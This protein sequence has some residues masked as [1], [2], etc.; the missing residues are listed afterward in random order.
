MATT[1]PSKLHY[2]RRLSSKLNSC[3]VLFPFCLKTGLLQTSQRVPSRQK[4][5]GWW[6]IQGDQFCLWSTLWSQEKGSLWQT[7]TQRA[8]RGCPWTWWLWWWHPLPLLWWWTLW[9]YGRW[10]QEDPSEGWRHC[11]PTEVNQFMDTWLISYRNLNAFLRVTLED[12]YNGKTSKLQLSKNV[13][14]SA[15]SGYVLVF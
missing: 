4:S 11:T 8:A 6:K 15:C 5:W 3:L 10:T 9:W 13:I 7:W 2:T 14:C 12:L 1:N